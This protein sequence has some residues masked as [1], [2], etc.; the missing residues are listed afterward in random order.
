MPELP[1]VETVANALRPYLLGHAVVAIQ[2][3]TTSLRYPL[4]LHRRPELLH[5]PIERVARRAKHILIELDN[6]HVLVLH[7]GMSGSC[8]VVDATAPLRRHDH[9][10]LNLDDG[11]SFRFNDPRKFGFIVATTILKPGSVPALLSDLPPEPFDDAFSVDYLHAAL[12][13][14][15]R[16]VKAIVMDNHFVAGVGNIY[17]SESLFVA[18][19]K[20]Q[21]PG[22]QISRKRAE[23][24]RDSIRRVLTDAIR[25]G[26]TTIATYRTVSGGEG[27]FARELRVYGREGEM[28]TQCRQGR[29]RR[30][31]MAGRSTYYC[32]TCQR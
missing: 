13:G 29:I 15:R 4:D 26:G 2:L 30:I 10:V 16:P 21:T 32:A 25:A 14:R 31:V 12:R 28:C 17:A 20:P 1:E 7:L 19:I 23:R 6:R 22:Q 11:S 18:G 24:L 3:Y 8:R 27:L 9:V 5:S